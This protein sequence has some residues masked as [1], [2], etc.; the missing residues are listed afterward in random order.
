M[1]D[2]VRIAGVLAAAFA[3]TFLV[4]QG[5][6]LLP[7][8][9]VIRWLEGLREVHPLWLAAGVVALLLLDLLVAVPTMATI[10]LAGWLLGPVWGGVTAGVGLMLM[11][12]L[13][14]MAGRLAGRPVLRR[15]L[16]DEARLAGIE[17]A[18]ARNDLLVL[19]VCQALPILPELSATLAGI[20]RMHPLRFALGY[21]AG[22][23]P[24]AFVVAFGGAASSPED[25]RPAVLT[26]IGVS[27]VLL[28]A[29]R[30]LV[31]R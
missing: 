5:L 6:G 17:T 19:A 24:F 10:L 15:L 12:S 8:D 21:A 14:Y 3:S 9:G 4:V 26:V 22:V 30:V 23:V 28:G 16:R 11:G 29:W 31:R 27:A 2:L 18:F 7:E 13:G 20:A 25:L 1:G